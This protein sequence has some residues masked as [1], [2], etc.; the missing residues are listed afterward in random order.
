MGV[1]LGL[2]TGM[3]GGRDKNCGEVKDKLKTNFKQGI[4]DTVESGRNLVTFERNI[5]SPS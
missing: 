5:L 4:C 1:V 2:V 3:E